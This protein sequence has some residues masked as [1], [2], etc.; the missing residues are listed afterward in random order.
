[1]DNINNNMFEGSIIHHD[2]TTNTVDVYLGAVPEI[3][4]DFTNGFDLKKFLV[5]GISRDEIK[6]EILY[7]LSLAYT[8]IM[9]H[10]EPK[11]IGN[12]GENIKLHY[13]T[14]VTKVPGDPKVGIVYPQFRR[15]A[16]T[17]SVK[18]NSVLNTFGGGVI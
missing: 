12:N 18:V 11:H 8:G 1:M 15:F 9:T 10:L 17:K 7:N 16:P 4:G 13:A 14:I 2:I 5:D 3:D 6:G